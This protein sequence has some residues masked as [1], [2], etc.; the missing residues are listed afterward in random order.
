MISAICVTYG[1][2]AWL[3]EAIQSFLN[4]DLGSVSA[5]LVVLNTFQDQT[6]KFQHDDPI[7]TVLNLGTRPAS[8]GE[9]RNK[10][11]E[12]CRGDIIVIWD[13]DDICLPKHL[14]TIAAAFTEDVDWVWMDKQFHMEGRQIKS[15]VAGT[16]P[17]FAFR[18]SAWKAIGGYPSLTVG[19]D[20]A[21]IGK[22]ST[23]FKGGPLAVKEP[24]FIYRWGQGTYHASGQGPDK[25]GADRAHDRIRND[26]MDRVR[27]GKEPLGDVQLKPGWAQ[28][29]TELARQFLGQVPDHPVIGPDDVCVVELGRYGDIINI[30]PF[31]LHV[32]NTYRTPYL[33]VSAEFESLLE[34]VSYVHPLVVNLPHSKLLRA[35]E[36]AERQFEFVIR[37][38]I[39]GEGWNQDRHIGIFNMESWRVAGCLHEWNNETWRPLFDQRDAERERL[40]LER[41]TQPDKPII[42][43][44]VTSAITAPL[45]DGDK[46]LEDIKSVWGAGGFANIVDMGSLR[47]HRLF[48]ALALMEKAHCLVTIDTSLLHLAVGSNIPVV[49]LTNPIPWLGSALRCN[50][51]VNIPYDRANAQNVN[52]GIA[53][54][55]SVNRE[56]FNIM[57]PK[58]P[59]F[60]R[61]YHV[62]ERHEEPIPDQR[63]RKEFAQR[64]WDALYDQGVV[65]CH[66]WVYKRNAHDTIGD[67]RD[68]PYLKDVLA[69]GLGQTQ[70]EDDIVFWCN[71][72][73]WLH[74]RLVARLRCHCA[75]Y[76]ACT[77]Q[78]CEFQGPIVPG[79]TP[80]EYAKLGAYHMG[81]DI[82]AGTVRWFTKHWDEIPDFLLGASDFDLC[83][84]ALVRK[85]K[86]FIT[87]R[88][89]IEDCIWPCELPRGYVCHQHHEPFWHRPDNEHTAPSQLYNRKLFREWVAKYAPEI[90]LTPQ[91][92]L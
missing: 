41:I 51:V 2:T 29:Y 30:L 82:F 48:D 38:Q 78:R 11:I 66:T 45:K 22:I 47:L 65:P 32:H 24:T 90:L 70:G 34:G 5:E 37:S 81:R 18:K 63:P 77:S 84:A 25:P 86:G 16:C 57:V 31:C 75:I 68:L 64:S 89:N 19:E 87:N 26:L 67:R 42:L 74:P 49:A 43:V 12:S 53:E 17:L 52:E 13:D 23:Q 33:M 83:L 55:V 79:K 91:G 56:P 72:D 40:L 1:R 46:L 35:M 28:D 36:I 60:R 10:A 21:L 9:A 54:A 61:L 44:N 58:A 88:K 62:V 69:E 71:D 59:P 3:Q 27:S 14:Q 6:L 50:Y 15:I 73:N 4:Q 39:W 7:V 20:R 85:D 76:E 92:L 80:A 8:L